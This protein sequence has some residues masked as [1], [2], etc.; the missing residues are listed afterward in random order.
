MTEF[1]FEKACLGPDEK[2]EG[3]S[4]GLYPWGT[5]SAESGDYILSNDGEPNAVL[6]KY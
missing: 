4:N 1:E 6:R 2:V 5:L 3:T